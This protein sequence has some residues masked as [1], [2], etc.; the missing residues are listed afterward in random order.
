MNLIN[1]SSLSESNTQLKISPVSSITTQFF[2]LFRK[3]Y[4]SLILYFDSRVI[5]SIKNPESQTNLISESLLIKWIKYTDQHQPCLFH[6]YSNCSVQRIKWITN[7]VVWFSNNWINQKPW[8]LMFFFINKSPLIKWIKNTVKHR[9]CSSHYNLNCSIQRI[10]RITNIV[11]WFLND[12]MNQKLWISNK[13][14][15]SL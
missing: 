4:E 15:T 11:V 7:I 5:E 12:W 6:Y 2:F 8:I 3:S 1:W 13:R 14:V 10:K 9:S